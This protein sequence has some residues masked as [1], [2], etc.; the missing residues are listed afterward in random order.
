MGGQGR[1]FFCS[2][3]CD[4]N[5][6]PRDLLRES[7]DIFVGLDVAP[8]EAARWADLQNTL[9]T[10]SVLLI[11]GLGGVGFLSFAQSFRA[12]R[13]VLRQTTALAA[14]VVAAMMTTMSGACRSVSCRRCCGQLRSSGRVRPVDFV[15]SQA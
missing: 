6:T 2:D 5:G 12:Q 10:A 15:P 13:R 4:A 7:L 14:E 11:A 3:D 8:I 1:H 9:I